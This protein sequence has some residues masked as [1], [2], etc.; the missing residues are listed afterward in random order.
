MNP[1]LPKST[2]FAYL[3]KRWVTIVTVRILTLKEVVSCIY[4]R[5]TNSRYI[6]C[7][8]TLQT[9]SL[10]K[11]SEWIMKMFNYNYY[12]LTRT[13]LPRIQF[14]TRLT[15]SLHNRFNVKAVFILKILCLQEQYNTRA[16]I[17]VKLMPGA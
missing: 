13:I 8:T 17:S 3:S 12:I 16:G 4:V 10:G 7:K 14:R 2:F 6:W 15:L 9:V 5:V 11:Y 1:H